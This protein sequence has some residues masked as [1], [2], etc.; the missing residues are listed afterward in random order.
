MIKNHRPIHQAV[1]LEESAAFTAQQIADLRLRR[2]ARTQAVHQYDMYLEPLF[3]QPSIKGCEGCAA[4]MPHQ[5][6][7]LHALRVFEVAARASSFTEAAKQLHLTHGAVSRQIAL[8]E[9][10]LGQPLFRKQGQRM[11]ATAHAKAY[12]REISQAFDHIGDATHR[13]GK[14]ATEKVIRVNA[15]ATMAMRWL[16]PRLADFHARH[17]GI[18]VRV[19]TAFSTEPALQGSFD[20]AIRRASGTQEQYEVLTLYTETNTVI[21]SPDLWHKA[22][23]RCV[24]ELAQVIWLS[25]ETRPGDWEAW[26]QSAGLPDLRPVQMLR[27]D[28]FFVSLQAV[29]DG[30][31]YAVAPFPTLRSDQELG[32]IYAPFPELVMASGTFEALVPLDTDKPRHLRVFLEWLQGEC[33]VL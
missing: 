24:Q 15:P 22:P 33:G 17:S 31:G 25:T 5:L 8:L 26:L 9:A 29:I 23:L 13:Y 11:V 16:I 7:P 14:R 19:S 32:R 28:H 10:A 1:T 30:L 12:A 18:E 20:V 3:W 4:H 27:F 2:G 6:P 21:V